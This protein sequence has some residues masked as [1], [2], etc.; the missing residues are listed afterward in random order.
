[1]N[2]MKIAVLRYMAELGD[3]F[4]LPTSVAHKT[5]DPTLD[6]PNLNFIAPK[7]VN[8]LKDESGLLYQAGLRV[9]SCT[10]YI[11]N[12]ILFF[13]EIYVYSLYPLDL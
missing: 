10:I 1:M 9:H 13:T 7:D 2:R 3:V 6:L 4:T 5:H 12:I 8:K 11:L